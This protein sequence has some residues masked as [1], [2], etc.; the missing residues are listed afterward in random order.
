MW[1]AKSWGE[2]Q[3]SFSEYMTTPLF[4]YICDNNTLLR[5]WKYNCDSKLSDSKIG[6]FSFCWGNQL[7]Q[8]ILLC[9]ALM[10][11]TSY[12]IYHWLRITR[13]INIECLL[14]R[15]KHQLQGPQSTYNWMQ[16][17]RDELLI[18]TN[19]PRYSFGKKWKT[20]RSTSD[21]STKTER[22]KRSR[23]RTD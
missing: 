17:S 16:L 2:K 15:C 21:V 13:C 12:S 4:P 6:V 20:Q 23:I 8:S 14:K 1:D 22:N 9:W 11:P 7:D 18:S 5:T 10:G 3:H 19:W